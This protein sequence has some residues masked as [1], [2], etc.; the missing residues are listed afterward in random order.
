M[1]GDYIDEF[2]MTGTLIIGEHIRNTHIRFRNVSD[3]ESY[4]N[5][6]D[7]GYDYKD[8]IFNG[9]NYIT[10]TPVFNMNVRSRYRNACDFKHELIEYRGNNCLIP[11]KGYCFLKS[12][13]Y[14]TGKKYKKKYLDFIRNGKRRCNL[15]TIARVQ[16]YLKK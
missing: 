13:I 12:F 1:L 9:Y 8:T 5:S 11:V 7:E 16:P 3:F 14:L 4:I 2:E 6:T 15:M 10:Y